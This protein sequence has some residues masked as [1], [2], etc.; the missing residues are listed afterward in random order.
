[1]WQ[2]NVG[3]DNGIYGLDPADGSVEA[4][5]TGEPWAGVSQRGL[6]Y[7]P[8]ADVFYIGGWN[9]GVIYRVAGPSHPTPG[10]TLDQ[11]SPEDPSISGLAWNPAFGLLWM[12]TNSD[13]DSIY[14]VD[15]TTCETIR[16]L[17]HPD[18][19][20]FNGAGIEIDVVG[21]LWLTGQSSGNAYL[22]E[23][24][25]PVFSDVPWLTESPTE[26]TVEP[27]GSARWTFTADST[28]LEPGIYR[29]IVVIGT[30]D[31]ANSFIQVPVTLVVPSYQQG[32]NAG[33]PAYMDGAGTLFA[34]DRP[35]SEGAFG[36]AGASSTRSTTSAIDGTVEDPLYQDLRTGMT[37]YS[38]T[39]AEGTYHVDL[40]FAEIVARKAGAR[41]FSITIE[42]QTVLANLDVLAEAGGRNTALDRSFVVEVT[43]GTS[44][45]GSPPSAATR[46]SSTRSS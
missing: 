26:G 34:P 25:L 20:D 11:C 46:R 18:G 42:G 27:D 35:F 39:V 7:D 17:P 22:V 12:A 10:E 41:I 3:G 8:A 5:V 31:P 44:T 13:T 36:F 28:G 29:S 37:G 4:V 43:D 14:L 24:G 30:N 2:V 33:G 15:P 1:M 16:A 40:A 9:E 6:A 38:F 19:G 45:S 23:S 32:V 21:N